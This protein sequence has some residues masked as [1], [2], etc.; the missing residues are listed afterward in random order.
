MSRRISQ[1]EIG[2]SKK[3]AKGGLAVALGKKRHEDEEREL[4]EIVAHLKANRHLIH[5]VHSSLFAGLLD[6]TVETKIEGEEDF[7]DSYDHIYRVPKIWLFS[8][9]YCQIEEKYKCKEAVKLLVKADDDIHLKLLEFS[10]LVSRGDP[11]GPRVRADWRRVYMERVRKVGLL[12]S[13]VWD[14]AGNI[15]WSKCGIY[16]LRPAAAEGSSDEELAKHRY[17]HLCVGDK[18][19][20]PLNEFAAVVNGLW[21]VKENWKVRDAELVNKDGRN[22]LRCWD[23]MEQLPTWSDFARPMYKFEEK[24]KKRGSEGD[25]AVAASGKKQRA[26]RTFYALETPEK[27]VK[28]VEQEKVPSPDAKPVLKPPPAKPKRVA[29]KKAA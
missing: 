14:G 12:Q 13:I 26:A 1:R 24:V 17:T 9:F 21:S 23:F 29:A 2:L 6:M 10:C 11:F 7:S 25:A 3:A 22:P 28:P 27:G 19:E 4:D 8:T 5:D 20:A 16:K 15:P 18:H